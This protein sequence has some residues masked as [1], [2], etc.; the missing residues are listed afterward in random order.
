MWEACGSGSMAKVG[1][2]A[3]TREEAAQDEETRESLADEEEDEFVPDEEEEEES[4]LSS[5][6][7][8]EESEGDDD[9]DDMSTSQWKSALKESNPASL[10]QVFNWTEPAIED[11]Y[12]SHQ[13]FVLEMVRGS[14]GTERG[15]HLAADGAYDSRGYSALIGKVVIADTRT[16][17]VLHTE[18]LHR[19][20]TGGVSGRMEIE[21]NRSKRWV[22]S[23]T[24]MTDGISQ[25]GLV[26]SF[27]RCLKRKDVTSSKCG[28]RT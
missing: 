5:E 18:V 13:Q 12:H 8:F 14:S 20:E 23:A 6:M 4:S 7:S 17:L 10:E 16:K 21:E 2:D 24:T 1:E 9:S 26:T 19:S 28:S 3:G 27:G 11:V 22:P 15:L 25:N